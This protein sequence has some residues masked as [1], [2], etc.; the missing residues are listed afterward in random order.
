MNEETTLL[1]QISTELEDIQIQ[2]DNTYWILEGMR[3]NH[4]R[5]PDT[6]NAGENRD[7][8]IKFQFHRAVTENTMD[9]LNEMKKRIDALVTKILEEE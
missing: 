2:L 7:Y 5:I 4:E 3:R 9:K 1:N 8:A 6:K